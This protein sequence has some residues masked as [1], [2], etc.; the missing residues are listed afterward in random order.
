MNPTYCAT[1]ATQKIWGTSR[2]RILVD[3]GASV[4]R[5]ELFYDD[6]LPGEAEDGPGA[7]TGRARAVA[8]DFKPLGTCESG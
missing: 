8:P 3:P 6:H 1:L 7:K 2:N 4:E 5:Q